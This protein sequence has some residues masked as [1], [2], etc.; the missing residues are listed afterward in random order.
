M[1]KLLALSLIL[2]TFLTSTGFLGFFGLGSKTITDPVLTAFESDNMPQ[3]NYVYPLSGD[4]ALTVR[5]MRSGSTYNYAQYIYDAAAD[6]SYPITMRK[7]DTDT[8]NT[9]IREAIGKNSKDLRLYL[10]LME[11][12]GPAA[13]LT[14]ERLSVYSVGDR[15]AYCA[16]SLFSGLLDC[17]T[18]ELLPVDPVLDISYITPWDELLRYDRLDRGMRFSL[19]DLQGHILH[20]ADVDTG[21]CILPV[22]QLLEDGLCIILSDNLS[23]M[24]DSVISCVLLDRELNTSSVIT[25]AEAYPIY[26]IKEAARAVK[27]GHFLLSTGEGLLVIPDEGGECLLISE[28]NGEMTATVTTLPSDQ[29]K[30]ADKSHDM[31]HVIGFAQDGSCALLSTKNSGLYK[32]DMNTLT[33]SRQMTQMELDSYD[34]IFSDMMGMRWNGSEYAVYPNGVM[35]VQNR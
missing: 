22:I 34:L 35:R 15:Y 28:D 8:W 6:R 2:I 1:K 4:R 9:I 13:L 29:L 23:R 33:L 27:T 30:S 20:T 26:L 24:E 12:E 21:D 31:I 11:E 17:R 10:K 14:Y 7:K 18:G 3:A 19:M 5:T 32:L 25:V 16:S